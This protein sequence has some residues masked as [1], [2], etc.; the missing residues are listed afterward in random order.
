MEYTCHDIVMKRP[1]SA[2]CHRWRDSTPIGSGITGAMLYGGV[3][4]EHI[5]INRNDLWSGGKD[6]PVPDISYC[7]EQMRSL[8]KAGKYREAN[9]I[10]YNALVENSYETQLADMRTLGCVKVIFTCDG[11][12]SNYSRVIHTNTSE[13]EISYKIDNISYNRRYIASRK[14]DLIAIEITS[15]EKTGFRLESGFFESFEGDVENRIKENDKI[16]AEYRFA[17]NCYIYSSCH[18]G[19]YFGIVCS[20]ISDGETGVSEKGI[21][22]SECEKSLILIKA[23]SCENDRL[24]GET[25]A[26]KAITECPRSFEAVFNENLTLYQS[27]Y[28]SAEIKLYDGKEYHTNEELMTQAR[29]SKLSCELA[30]K[31]WR[32]GRYLFISGTSESALPF[33]LYG[34]WPGGY[35]QMF[36]HHVANEN[37]QSIYWHTEAGGL[38]GLVPALIDYYYGK[39]DKFRE[40]ARKLFGCRGIFA[41]TYTTPVNSTVAWYV[42]VIVN[43][44]GVA[45]WLSQHFYKY[46]LY[47]GDNELFEDKILPFMTEAAEFY[48]DYYYTDTDGKLALYPAVSPENSPLEYYDKTKPHSM[49]VT[50]NPT[51]EIAI[52]KEL[53]SNLTAISETRPELADKAKKW[54]HMLSVIPEYRIN[55]DGAIAEWISPDLSDAYDHRH[56]SHIYPVF[57]GTEIEDSGNHEL[58]RAFK[59]AV[60][61]R[62]MGSFC[63]WSM[64]HMS[65]IYSRFGD[66]DNAFKSLNA[67]VKVCLLE[68]FFTLGYDFRD[69]GITGFECG[70]EN[71]AC[72]QLDALMSYVNAIQEML[73]FTANNLVRLLP[74][75]PEEFA[76][77]SAALHIPAGTLDMKWNLDEKQCHGT[78]TA[79]RKTSFTLELPFGQKSLSISLSKNETFNF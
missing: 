15:G 73:V 28:N 18:E 79:K 38:S 24:E 59:R 36:T 76:N 5:I 43:F 65:A 32:F 60:D 70:G 40:N 62:E 27:L 21:Y 71:S 66:S 10:M 19:K 51:V 1:S 31:L 56:L 57:P 29:D 8:Q 53:L 41:G 17:D 22:V 30:E 61:L 52:L 26:I 55:S 44:I 54:K 25:K 20:I 77:G 75:C 14:R 58:M 12:Y 11:I 47:T 23:F 78:I 49:P 7:V 46:Y 37:V 72:V 2:Y 50:K 34:L 33:P 64:P 16:S 67:L 9:D 48:E 74:A 42:P 39:M 45:G 6:A 35:G 4:A 68:N 63:G 13:A 3:S 69:M